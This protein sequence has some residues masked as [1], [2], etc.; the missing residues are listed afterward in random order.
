VHPLSTQALTGLS[1]VDSGPASRSH[2]EAGSIAEPQGWSGL[3]SPQNPLFWFG[4]ILA[5]T[6]GLIGVSGSARVGRAKVSAA[7]DKN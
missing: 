2:L 7:L 5:V 4:G 1:P 3:L 6:F